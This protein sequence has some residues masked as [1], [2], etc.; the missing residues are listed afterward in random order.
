MT[1]DTNRQYW[2][3]SARNLRFRFNFAVWLDRF[4]KGLTAF[5]ILAAVG[6]LI[7]RRLGYSPS[8]VAWSF[9]LATATSL[10][11]SIRSARLEFI[12]SKE[13]L[14]RLDEAYQLNSRLSSATGGVGSFPSPPHEP[15]NLL[16]PYRWKLERL[17]LLLGVPAVLI[18]AASLVP[19]PRIVE[20]AVTPRQPPL[21]VS[22]VQKLIEKLEQDAVVEKRD[23]N[24]LKEQAETITKQDPDQWYDQHSLEA[25]DTLKE[26]AENGAES[27]AQSLEQASKALG[28]LSDA[29]KQSSPEMKQELKAQLDNAIK[30][31]EEGSMH[32]S[33]ELAKQLS[34]LSKANPDA[35]PQELLDSIKGKLKSSA[36]ILKEDL[37]AGGEGGDQKSGG[38]EG[39]GD[40][41]DQDGDANECDGDGDGG[42]CHSGKKKG[43][44]SGE[45]NGGSSNSNGQEGPGGIS[46]GPGTA[47][48]RLKEHSPELTSS[49]TE[50]LASKGGAK[51]PGDLVGM[52]SQTPETDKKNS[53]KIHQAGTAGSSAT[54]GEAVSSGVYTPDENEV[55][56]KYFR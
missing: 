11:L 32:P 13:A 17:G 44:K 54:G 33:E 29:M 15:V 47:P 39:K 40:G 22:E 6:I 16:P 31:L 51:K 49:R 19:V 50:E 5:S 4:L 23:L 18:S 48:L 46:R 26:K 36:K 42:M 45:G 24:R 27:L 53:S 9:V 12:T 52:T 1:D 35:I 14:I 37:K 7:C 21:A 10:L 8:P 43:N 2:N 38:M 34:E 56:K 20:A 28:A 25:A 3:R 41:G 55:L 30:Q